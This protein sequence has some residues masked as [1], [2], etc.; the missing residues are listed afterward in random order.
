M[1]CFLQ[2]G[3][4]VI[5]VNLPV[6]PQTSA[7]LSKRCTALCVGDV[8]SSSGSRSA[9]NKRFPFANESITCSASIPWAFGAEAVARP[10]FVLWILSSVVADD[11]D[12]WLPAEDP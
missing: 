10:S 7:A 4:A 2:G 9:Q 1:E 3:T 12:R 5:V 8:K 11:D 6:G